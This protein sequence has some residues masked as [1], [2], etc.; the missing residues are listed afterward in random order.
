MALKG[1]IYLL[2]FI[3]ILSSPVY[4]Y[5]LWRGVKKEER[6]LVSDQLSPLMRAAWDGNLAQMQNILATN[7]PIDQR[8][9]RGA[10]ALMYACV[11][12]QPI[13]VGYLLK[14]G[15]KKGLQTHKGN[16]AMFFAVQEKNNE[17]ISLLSI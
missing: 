13:I 8:D 10:T 5:L 12:N 9:E 3:V 16:T 15:A 2:G 4:Q 6:L 11:A 17:I 7:S 1:W 14:N